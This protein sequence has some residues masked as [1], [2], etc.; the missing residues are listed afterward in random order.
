MLLN[1]T[2]GGS[3]GSSD[4]ENLQS[5]IYRKWKNAL[6]NLEEA[7]LFKVLGRKKQYD[8][9]VGKTYPF[10][11]AE[12]DDWANLFEYIGSENNVR[13]KFALDKIGADLND[14]EIL[15]EDSINGD[16]WDKFLSSLQKKVE[17]V[18]GTKAIQLISEAPE[19]PVSPPRGERRRLLQSRPHWIALIAVVI[20][21]GGAAVWGIR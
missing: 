6:P 4:L 2:V 14:V 7:P 9:G 17:K 18:P 10:T 21:I 11:D 15:Y 8:E 3:A 20:T 16:A 1:D 13:L 19:P 12:K 5:R